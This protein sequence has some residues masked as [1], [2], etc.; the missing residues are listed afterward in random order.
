MWASDRAVIIV[1]EIIN[2]IGDS[3]PLNDIMSSRSGPQMDLVR[4]PQILSSMP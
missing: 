2:C 1:R 4:L 3:S